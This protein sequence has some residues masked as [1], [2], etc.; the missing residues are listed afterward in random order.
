[1]V[2]FVLSIL[3]FLVLSNTVFSLS[4]SKT[5][6]NPLLFLTIGW[7]IP[8]IL[9]FFAASIYTVEI[10]Q[11]FAQFILL[12]SLIM[13][14]FIF[15]GMTIYVRSNSMHQ[16]TGP[17]IIVS[18]RN[19]KRRWR[20]LMLVVVSIVAISLSFLDI[21]SIPLLDPA[22]YKMA[23]RDLRESG[24]YKI[25]TIFLIAVPL[26]F[27]ERQFGGKFSLIEKTFLF[28]WFLLSALTGWVGNI[29]YPVIMVFAVL[30][31]TLNKKS[32]E[33]SLAIRIF[34]ALFLFFIIIAFVRSVYNLG[35]AP[36][37]DTLIDAR[38]LGRFLIYICMPIYNLQEVYLASN[39][40][41][42]GANTF[43]FLGQIPI[44]GS[45]IAEYHFNWLGTLIF[46]LGDNIYNRG[47]NTLTF[48]APLYFDFGEFGV[49][50]I[51]PLCFFYGWLYSKATK[52][53]ALGTSPVT[54]GLYSSLSMVFFMLFT[55]L[56]TRMLS[57]YLWPLVVLFVHKIPAVRV[58]PR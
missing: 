16:D 43:L 31:I 20:F 55:G 29:V 13:Q 37:V 40:R 33:I 51:L 8:C 7:L 52:G 18:K 5:F 28:L 39:S 41:S 6:L 57:F 3:C 19:R 2:I 36:N 32:T 50:L 17:R 53:N 42:L 34:P 4:Y 49:V 10:K 1:M 44:I 35:L 12:T 24:F 58:R 45:W 25:Y 22:N 11:D 47:A 27:Y 48:I 14:A 46:E 54:F 23:R 26:L 38:T 30:A 15:L 21:G 56:H 9:A